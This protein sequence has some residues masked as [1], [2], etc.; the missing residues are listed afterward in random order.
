MRLPNGYGS[1]YK[2]SGNRRKPWIAR[3]TIGWSDEGKQLYHTIG[4]FENRKKAMNA[5]IEFNNN[6]YD[7]ETADI[8]FT[9]IFEMW[10][11]QKYPKISKSNQNGYNAAYKISEDLHDVKFN[12]IR[13][14]NLQEVI[15]N[16]DKG[17][18]T[19]KKVKTLY[20]QLYKYAVANDITNKDYSNYVDIGENNTKSTRKPFT[21][22]EIDNLWEN[23][24]RMDFIDTIL[25]MIY[26][27]IRPGELITIKNENID[28]E[29]RI[30]RGGIKTKAAIDRVIPLNKKIIPLIEKRMNENNEYLVINHEGK[31]MRYWNYYEEKWKKI[32][33]QL[34]MKHKPHDCRHT[35]ATFMDNARANKVSIKRIMGHA[36][37][38]ITDKVY[39]HKDIEELKKAIDLI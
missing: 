36:S 8:T 38:D 21:K 11:K 5:L 10:S 20:N 39:T 18:S 34:K 15:D 23:V 27:G 14:A 4:Y 29:N 16:C 1:V 2:L 35:F 26:T 25:I 9:E 31:K 30:M 17:Y 19:K 33:E 6:P 12:K 3:K 22:D 32:M 28:L 7:I 13:A 37:K 24:N